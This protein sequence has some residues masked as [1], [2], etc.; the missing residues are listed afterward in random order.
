MNFIS[1]SLLFIFISI[2]S[3]ATA[4]GDS[5]ITLKGQWITEP[6][7]NA[8][9]DPQTSGLKA[10]RGKFISLSDASAD[11]SQQK[12]IHII[13]GSTGVLSKTSLP[14][15]LSDKV[16]KGCFAGYLDDTPDLEG[17]AVDKKDD[18]VFY[19]VTE[20]ARIGG[21][22][23]E[24][25]QKR[26]KNTGS[27]DYPTLLL[28]LALQSDN[29][30]LTTHVRPIQFHPSFEV[31]NFS[32]DGIEGLATG[33]DDILYLAL[34]KDSHKKARIFSIKMTKGFWQSDDFIP[35]EDP[36]FSTP[37]FTQGNHPINGLDY[38]TIDN[39]PGY[40]VAAA[41][42]DDQLWIIDIAKTKSTKV[43]SLKFLAPTGV[44]DGSCNAWDDLNNTSLE[45]VAVDGNLIWL[46][47]DPWKKHYKANILCESN[48]DKFKSYSPLIFSL[49]IDT[50][51]IN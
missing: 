36:G 38:L 12:Q 9:L 44:K 26:F 4:N 18:K 37:S 46:V 51:W 40:L 28:R 6:D 49:P 43:V 42:N 17:L 10:W 39:H 29:T 3:V 16:A 35:V 2:S 11:K 24:N 1:K 5:H 48:A 13:D 8:M 19:V 27:T 32:N 25:C 7:G 41:R 45:G 33:K 47:N 50:N 14:I 23:S 22:L 15:R 34:E 20:D 21:N 30:V 31:G